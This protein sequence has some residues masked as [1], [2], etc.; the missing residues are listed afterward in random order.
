MIKI[1]IFDAD[2]MIVHGTRFSARLAKKFDI[3]TDVTKEFFK[4]VF[5]D[6]IVGKA[7]L[8]EELPAYFSSWGWKG[9]LEEILEF[10]FSPEYNL[11]DERFMPFIEKL[12]E[13]GIKCYLA[14]NNEKYRTQNLVDDR[15]IGKWFDGIFSSAV[16]GAKKPEPDFF[17]YILSNL[18]DVK[19]EEVLFWDDDT[20][21]I[22]GA[23]SVGLKTQIYADFN[24]FKKVAEE[25]T[26][27]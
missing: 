27:I 15:G 2:G 18:T 9:S 5:Q 1:V 19:K 16:I 20:K 13:S 11:I 10:W 12:R 7:D 22:E 4:G 21:N 17:K 8:R 26:I 25:L 14:T 3:S 6:C 24:E 23:E